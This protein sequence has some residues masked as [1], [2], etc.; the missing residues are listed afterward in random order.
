MATLF[1][2]PSGAIV[3]HLYYAEP[4]LVGVPGS[5]LMNP[6]E[7][8]R[9]HYGLA[10]IEL[11]RLPLDTSANCCEEHFSCRVRSFFRTDRSGV[12]LW[13]HLE[14]EYFTG[15]D[16]AHSGSLAVSMFCKT[17]C[18]SYRECVALG[19]INESVVPSISDGS[20]SCGTGPGRALAEIESKLL[21]WIKHKA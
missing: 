8:M 21:R 1:L 10:S 3:R 2:E 18:L 20:I 11:R 6:S 15:P 4:Q 12:T 16:P 13:P 5:A 19:L 17:R 14:G 9:S 7:E